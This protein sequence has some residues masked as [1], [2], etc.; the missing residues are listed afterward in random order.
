M[1]AALVTPALITAAQNGDRDAIEAVLKDA[2]QAIT[3]LAAQAAGQYQRQGG[4]DRDQLENDGRVAAWMAIGRFDAELAGEDVVDS[5]RG[6]IYKTVSRAMQDGIRGQR[7][8]GCAGADDDAIKVFGQMLAESD[9]D[10][11]LAEQ[12]CR[13]VPPAGRRL[14]KDRARAARMAWQ[15]RTSLDQPI[16]DEGATLGESLADALG[17]PEDMVTADD[18]TRE[19]RR[20]RI[21][22]VR[23]VLDSMGTRQADVLRYDWG[24]GVDEVE[25]TEELAAILGT[26]ARIISKARPNA[27]HT[28]EAKFIAAYTSSP[29]EAQAWRESAAQKRAD[30]I[31]AKARR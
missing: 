30:D 24:I 14:D 15:G 19:Q 23:A 28:F 11:Y 27:K 2:E 9:N 6:F 25:T 3:R 18:I 4:A 29:A 26:T 16:G 5:L 13:H 20:I 12:K 17:I 7:F 21:A 31:R 1:S 10:L 8:D 22:N